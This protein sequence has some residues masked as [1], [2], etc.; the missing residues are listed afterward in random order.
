MTIQSNF[1]VVAP[2]GAD[3]TAAL[4]ELLAEMK[5][6]TGVVQPQNALVPFGQFDRLHFARFL[7]LDDKTL[8]DITVYGIPRRDF[9]VSLAFLGDCDGPA[10]EFLADLVARAGDGLR[11]IFSHC[12]GFPKDAD[13]LTWMQ[14]H[15]QPP[16]AAYVNWAGRTVRQVREEE[17][18]YRAL[19]AYIDANEVELRS[20]GLQE[21]HDAMRKFAAA[22][23]QAGRLTLTP[24]STS[25]AAWLMNAVH[26]VGVLLILLLFAPLLLLYLPL[27]LVQLRLRER[28]DPEITPRPD[29]QH[30]TELA[31]L[32]D[33]DIT[34]Q[35]SAIG[36]LKPGSLRR[37][38]AVFFLWM[39]NN[40]A[41]HI[42]YRG[43][44]TRVGTIHFARW[45]FLNDKQRILFASNYDGSLESY[46]DDFI[47]KVGWGLNIVFS[48][49]VGYPR[50][51]WLL[52][53]GAKN[54][55]KFKHFLRRHQLPTEVWYNAHPGLTALD[56]QRNTRIRA[57]I[58]KVSMSDA[59]IEKW[60]RLF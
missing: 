6:Q 41:R 34:N 4:R 51:D 42:Y 22:E 9:P 54:E 1:M 56:L 2:L 13:L 27:F 20:E 36:T 60:L 38:L 8:H 16:A 5:D 14:Q 52:L 32:E 19:E 44:L 35:F 15:E 18:L 3:Q 39:L 23:I 30:Q 58:D 12:Q 26:A 7:I 24:E 21:R 31:A 17:V 33:H 50:T 57:G 45:V 49:G 53:H 55:Q 40:A 43:H 48:N 25:F 11:R 29:P 59:E 28:S 10:D 47:N 46:M 37:T